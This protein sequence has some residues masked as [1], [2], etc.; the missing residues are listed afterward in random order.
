MWNWSKYLLA[1]K[2]LYVLFEKLYVFMQ[3]N[4]LKY[5]YLKL[6]RAMKYTMGIIFSALSYK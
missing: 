1:V 5:R 3:N 6:N 4:I 2:K